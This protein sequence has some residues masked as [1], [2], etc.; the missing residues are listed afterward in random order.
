MVRESLRVLI[1]AGLPRARIHY[2]D[3]LLAG[4]EPQL[5]SRR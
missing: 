5:P 1:Q 2:D 3:A 4:P